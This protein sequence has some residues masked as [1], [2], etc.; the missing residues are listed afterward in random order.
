M[1][2]HASCV[3]VQYVHVHV[4]VCVSACTCVCECVI[5]SCGYIERDLV[6]RQA[7]LQQHLEDLRV[8]ISVLAQNR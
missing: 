3:H 4:C 2:V 7:Q 1:H 8:A 5:V 6:A